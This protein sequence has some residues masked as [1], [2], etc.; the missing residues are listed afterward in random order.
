[1]SS[2]RSIM[3][4]TSHFTIH[5][6]SCSHGC[7]D[8]ILIVNYLIHDVTSAAHCGCSVYFRLCY[9]GIIKISLFKFNPCIFNR[10]LYPPPPPHLFSF[11]PPP[12][13]HNER[14]YN[15]YTR[16][17]TEIKHNIAIPA[18]VMMMTGLLPSG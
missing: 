5:I 10:L 17:A 11:S 6:L 14:I 3:T 7:A 18:N 16:S 1:M 12:L 2:I 13:L 4:A 8:R 15:Y 9:N